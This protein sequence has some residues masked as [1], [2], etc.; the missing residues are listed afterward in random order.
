MFRLKTIFL[1]GALTLGVQA[2]QAADLLPPPPPIEP[3]P[4]AFGGWYLRGDV[5]A[6]HSTISDLRSTFAPGFVVENA[7]F[8]SS[9]LGSSAIFGLGAGYQFNNWF[10]ADVT[11]EYRT[12]ATYN[13]IQSYGPLFCGSFTGRCYEGYRGSISSAVFLA[14][15]YVDLGTW[16]GVTPYVGAGVGVANVMF[17]GPTDTALTNTGGYGVAQD[18]NSGHLAWAVMAGLSYN[19]TPN[20]KLDFG[21]RYLNMGNVSSGRIIC[22]DNPCSYEV[23]H[24]KLAS[25]DV[26]IGL[27][28]MFVDFM[29]AP[30]L[31]PPLVAKY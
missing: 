4:V 19:L 25:H 27:R 6:G 3:A 14:N 18:K 20:L 13:A 11:G 1:G 2:A 8:E 30:V 7:R 31:S 12:A 22:N 10:R 24:L 9:S 5:G 17:R 16:Y 29:P 26:R 21:Y 15:G 28:Y 23:Q